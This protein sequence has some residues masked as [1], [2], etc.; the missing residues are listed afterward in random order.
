MKDFSDYKFRCSSLGTI[1]TNDRSGKVMGETCKKYLLELW[2]EET[3]GRVRDFTNKYMEKGTMVEEESM[4]LYC[5]QR[6]KMF[7]K[8]Q[9]YFENEFICGHPDII[10]TAEVIDLKSCW[11]LF[12]F[13]SKFQEKISKDY[14]FQLQ[15]YM[16]LLKKDR[17]RLAYVLVDTPASL[18]EREK[19][20]LRYQMT[21]VIDHDTNPAYMQAAAQIEKNC[22]FGD[23]PEKDRWFEFK[24]EKKPIQP[25]YDRVIECRAF[26][27][28]LNAK[29]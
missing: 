21:D 26:L 19:S 11:D 6:K 18:I 1:M 20:K 25:V 27:N 5:V 7:I 24:L 23:I 16:E 22:T 2:I 28:D 12:T 13:Y 29:A 9:E 14:D 4:T 3:Y 17:A 15:G 8:N 10:D